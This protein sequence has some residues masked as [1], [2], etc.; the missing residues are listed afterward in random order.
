VVDA[1]TSQSWTSSGGMGGGGAEH[2]RR[3]A[4]V[5]RALIEDSHVLSREVGLCRLNQVDP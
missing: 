2:P 1:P 5:V 4:G 3:R